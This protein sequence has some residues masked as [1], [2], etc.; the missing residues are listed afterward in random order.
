MNPDDG[1]SRNA[2]IHTAGWHK[3]TILLDPSLP[4]LDA[5]IKSLDY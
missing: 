4:V 2:A 3:Q 1:Y 5:E